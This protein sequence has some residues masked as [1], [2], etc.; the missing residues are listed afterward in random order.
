MHAGK[1]SIYS[2]KEKIPVHIGYFTAWV[3][4]LGNINFYEDV[5]ERDDR[6]ALLLFYKE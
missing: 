5:Y 4:D 3:D 1:E 6:L 2:L